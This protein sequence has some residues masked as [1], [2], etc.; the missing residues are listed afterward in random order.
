MRGDLLVHLTILAKQEVLDHRML[1]PYV[2]DRV[3]ELL[4]YTIHIAAFLIHKRCEV[5]EFCLH[6]IQ[7]FAHHLHALL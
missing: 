4:I 1:A 3:S 5:D 2:L 6:L 7:A